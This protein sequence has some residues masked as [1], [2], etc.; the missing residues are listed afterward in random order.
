MEILSF[1]SILTKMCDDFDELISPRSIA[2]SNTNIVYLMFKAIA[3]GFE[4]VNN[5][6][7]VLSNKFNPEKCSEEDL[8]SVAS[9]V[10]TER[11]KGSASGLKI[12][13]SNT[14]ETDITLL[15]GTY[16][17]KL[18]DDTSF[19]FEVLTDTVIAPGS[20]ERYIAM[21]N[22]IGK[23]P[24]T[25]QQEIDVESS[26]PLPDGVKFS[27]QNN[28]E[29]LGIDTESLLDFRSRILNTYDRQNTMVELEEYLRNLP[30]LF[31]CAVRYN[32][33][34]EPIVVGG[35]VIPPMTCAIF[36]SGEAKNE[37]AEMVADYILC[38]TVATENSMEVKYENPVFASGEYVVNIIPFEKMNYSVELIYVVNEEYVNVQEAKATVET[39]LKLALNNEKHTDFIKEDDIYNALEELGH[40]GLDVLAVNLK[41][42]GSAVDYVAVPVS[43]VAELTNVSFVEG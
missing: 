30:Y 40:T 5:I 21:S 39:A 18:D 42:N 25:T 13:A 22:S 24:V 20:Q 10:G 14:G 28:E 36:F 3:K 34:I 11:R 43:K 29:L 41:V 1:D 6:C 12:L 37:I 27:C 26:A 4:L 9:L 32:Q 19:E 2:R 38:P 23:Y 16:V 17:Y 8:V 15:A 35:V 31:D 7:V 33:T